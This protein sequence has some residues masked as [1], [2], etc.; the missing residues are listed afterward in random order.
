MKSFKLT[1]VLTCMV[2]LASAQNI[3]FNINRG[4]STICPDYA[5]FKSTLNQ[6]VGFGFIK[7]KPLTSTL[8]LRT[9]VNFTSLRSCMSVTNDQG[10]ALLIPEKYFYVDMPLILEKNFFRYSKVTRSAS[11]YNVYGGVNFAYLFHEDGFETR[12]GENYQT[13]PINLGLTT[14]IQWV[15]PIKWNTSFA[16]GPQIQAY[17][18]GEEHANVAFYAGMKM[19]WKFGKY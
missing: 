7:T 6:A 15:K 8:N 13:R 4:I 16:I 5:N 17:T 19:D 12:V 18:T 2:A 11:H 1:L 14:G 9:G 3:G 10:A